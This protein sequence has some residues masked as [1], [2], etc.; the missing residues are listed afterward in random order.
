LPSLKPLRRKNLAEG[1]EDREY[2]VLYPPAKRTKEDAVE[3]KL[4]SKGNCV[5][6]FETD[7]DGV[8]LPDAVTGALFF[9]LLNPTFRRV[10]D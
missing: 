5:I 10:K 8:K 7:T 6:K 1:H 3:L 9:D 2:L 4:P